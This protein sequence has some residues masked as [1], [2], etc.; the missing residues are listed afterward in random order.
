MRKNNTSAAPRPSNKQRKND[1]RVD[2]SRGYQPVATKQS[3]KKPPTNPP[4]QGTA[5]KK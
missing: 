2:F 4:N 5:G 3:P 1:L